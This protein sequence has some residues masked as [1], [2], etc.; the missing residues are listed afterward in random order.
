VLGFARVSGIGTFRIGFQSPPRVSGPTRNVRFANR[1]RRVI[2][3]PVE[4]THP[5]YDFHLTAWGRA[6]DVFAGEDAVKSAGVRY[7]SSTGFSD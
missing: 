7:L 5:E 4:A 3:M 1:G 6:R 2:P